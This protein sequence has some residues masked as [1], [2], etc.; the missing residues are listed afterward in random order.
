MNI[1]QNKYVKD[2]KTVKEMKVFPQDTNHL[3]TMFG[4]S[5]TAFIDEVASIAANKHAQCDAV[6]ASMDSVDFLKP[7]E[8]GDAVIFEA[9]VTWVNKTSM[10]VFVKVIARNFNTGKKVICATS[11]LTFVAVDKSFNKVEVPKIIPESNEE[12]RLF[13]SAPERAE[14]RKQRKQ[15]SKNFASE[16]TL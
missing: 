5:I 14:R 1:S 16:F 10:E 2:T 7:V 3:G 8:M 15:E 4:G 9:F 13:E 6:T 12:I 11:F